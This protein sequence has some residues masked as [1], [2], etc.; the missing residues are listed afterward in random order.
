[1]DKALEEP[2]KKEAKVFFLGSEEG[3]DVV[4]LADEETA[5]KYTALLS[6]PPLAVAAAAKPLV[7]AKAKKTGPTMFGIGVESKGARPPPAA[8][9]P[10][11]QGQNAKGPKGQNAKAKGPKAKGPK[12]FPK[13]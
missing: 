6:P 1:M 11:G 9:G 4:G 10:K 13:I 8:K 3:G 5:A 12:N 7:V 2:L